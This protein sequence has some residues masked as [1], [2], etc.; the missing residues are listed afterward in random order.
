MAHRRSVLSLASA[1][2]A[3]LP[4]RNPATEAPPL[5][6]IPEDEYVEDVASLTELLRPG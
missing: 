1:Q 4:L 5:P 3:H 6:R 2:K